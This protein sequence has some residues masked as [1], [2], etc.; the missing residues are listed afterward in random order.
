MLYPNRAEQTRRRPAPTAGVL[1][2]LFCLNHSCLKL[3]PLFKKKQQKHQKHTTPKKTKTNISFLKK[4]KKKERGARRFR[5]PR[6]LG[7]VSRGGFESHRQKK[8]K[9]LHPN[10][11]RVVGGDVTLWNSSRL[12][13]QL[14][15]FAHVRQQASG[16]SSS[17]STA[18]RTPLR[19]HPCMYGGDV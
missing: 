11:G 10:S 6:F 14:R 3:S 13:R 5:L 4:K 17:Q 1:F 8:V 18:A 2:V 12:L 9:L 16:E 19:Q 7:N 15:E